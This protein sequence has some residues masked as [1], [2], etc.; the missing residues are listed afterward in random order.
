VVLFRESF[1]CH[2]EALINSICLFCFSVF[3]LT[4]FFLPFFSELYNCTEKDV[5]AFE[6]KMGNLIKQ[7]KQEREE[8]VEQNSSNKT[9][10]ARNYQSQLGDGYDRSTMAS[11]TQTN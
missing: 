7:R 9:K 8:E 11:Y 4:S 3:Q 5:T 6:K 2:Q 10:K 1:F